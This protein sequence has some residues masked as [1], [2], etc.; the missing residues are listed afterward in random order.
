MGTVYLVSLVGLVF[1]ILDL[2]QTNGTTALTYM[3]SYLHMYMTMKLSAD[4]EIWKYLKCGLK[5]RN[6]VCKKSVFVVQ[7]GTM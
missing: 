5:Q 4:S 6:T 2:S 1:N 3:L 7:V